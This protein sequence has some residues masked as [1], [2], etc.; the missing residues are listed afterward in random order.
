MKVSYQFSLVVGL[1]TGVWGQADNAWIQEQWDAIIVGSGPAGIVVASRLSEAG[2][3]TLLLEGGNQS[4]GVTGG[5]LDA[6][7]P[8][9]LSGTN[10]SRVDV[11]G[12]YK[13]IFADGGGLVCGAEVNAYGGCTI[14]GSSA[15]NAGLFFEPP[16]SDWDLYFPAEWNSTNMDASIQRLYDTQTSTNLTSQ[17]GIRSLQTGY[18]AARKWLVD[19][20]GYKDVDINA[21]ADDKT[22]VFGYPIFDYNN[23]QRGGPVTTY[24]QSALQRSNFRLQSGVR[25]VRVERDG[26]TA[27]GVTALINGVET[28]ISTTPTGRVVLSAGAIQSPSLLMYSG[29]GDAETLSKL[30]AAGKLSPNLTSAEWINNTAIGAGLFDNPNTFIEL[31]GDS[32]ESYTYSYDSPPADDKALYLDSRSGPYSF[33][34]E[35]SVFWTTI[36]HADGSIAGLQGTIDSSGYSD[37]T[38]NNTITLNVYGTSG[39]LSSGKVI[40]DDNFIP[41]PSDDVYYSN[42]RDAKDI[43][44]FIHTIFSALPNSGLTSM[45]IPQNATESEIETYITTASAYARGMVNHWSSSCRLGSC[46]DVDTTVIG[47]QNV[48][49][50]DASILAPVTTNPQFAVMAAGERASEL[51][52]GVA[53]LEC[54]FCAS[55]DE[56]ERE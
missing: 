46:V 24:L 52:L 6:R 4:Y 7:R 45:N 19:G 27:T 12:L 39:L 14:G 48:H 10:L 54:S 30:S 8:E 51:I 9:W 40:L 43:A 17:D 47:M 11:P 53:G 49:V 44:S 33:A 18:D 3:K 35:T 55:D 50:V 1:V 15:I 16:A 23:G 13:S 34:S 37:F 31:Q 5:D 22:D 25:V 38:T 21:Q 42:P 56:C 36:A 29:I 2:L 41:G 28:I 26:D 20:L 32:I